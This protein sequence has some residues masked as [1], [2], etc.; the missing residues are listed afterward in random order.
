MKIVDHKQGSDEWIAARVGRVG[1]SRISEI[2]AKTKSGYSTSRANYAAELVAER[3]T[4]VPAEKFS[5]AAMQWGTEHEADAR[6]LYEISSDCSVATVGLVLHPSIDMAQCSPDGLVGDNGLVEIKCPL[7]A[8]HISTLLTQTVEGK[9]VKQMQWQ[10]AC[11]GRQWC[12]FVSFDP[13]LPADMQL[14]V[15]RVKR[16][17]NA[18]AELETEVTRFLSEVDETIA[19]LTA[20]YGAKAAAE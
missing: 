4:G 12:D 2:V 20:L 11:T 18:I 1:A 9:Y 13:R 19:K 5:N 6:M 17:P 7:T 15:T 8:T 10:M 14:F 3:L 16:D